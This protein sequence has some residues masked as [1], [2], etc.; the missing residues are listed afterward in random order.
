MY[1]TVCIPVYNRAHTIVRTLDSLKNQT[2][3]DFEIVL[4]D[5]GSSDNIREVVQAWQ[6]RNEREIVCVHKENGGKHTALNRGIELAQGTFFLI[7][8]SDDWLKNDALEEMYCLCEKIK[9]DN[10]YS[11]IM[12]RCIDSESG[13]II[14]D[15]F[16]E[17]PMTLSYVDFHFR[18]G[19]KMKLGDCCECNKTSI[20]KNYRYPEPEGTKFVPEAWLFDQIGTTYELY[21]TNKPLEYKEYRA[22]GMSKNNMYKINNNIGFLYHYVSRL[23]NVLPNAKVPFKA[24]VIAWWRYWQAV[25]RD[26]EGKGP[27]CSRITSLG[28]LVKLAT[29]AISKIFSIR[30]KELYKAG[31]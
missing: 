22:D 16:P 24:H 29:P 17:D 18:L 3:Q 8:D 27:R 21:C 30:Y 31:R 25:D 6:E 28:I 2:F 15:L 9:D 5:D 13:R 7:L 23:E 12:G 20:M 26:R 19:Y 4:V 10:A 11:G 1:F 14:G